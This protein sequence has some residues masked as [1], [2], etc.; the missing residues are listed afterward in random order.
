MI[1]GDFNCKKIVWDDYE[2]VNGG[3]WVEELLN[4]AS[5]NLVT[6]WVRSPTGCRGQDV[7][8]R[9]D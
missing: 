6:Q 1:V 5:N 2:V 8:E 9:L 3:E 7:A 4:I